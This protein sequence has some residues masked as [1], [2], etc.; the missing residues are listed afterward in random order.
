MDH[1]VVKLWKG[2]SLFALFWPVKSEWQAV[3]VHII[4]KK[5]IIS[6]SINY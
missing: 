5:K 6:L 1:G 2:R 3:S 4:D